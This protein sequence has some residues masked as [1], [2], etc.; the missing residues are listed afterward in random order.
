MSTTTMFL[1]E[2]VLPAGT[3]PVYLPAAPRAIYVRDG[4]AHFDSDDYSQYIDDGNGITTDGQLTIRVG[5]TDTTLWRWE[6]AGG[7][8]GSVDD[9]D[10]AFRSAPGTTSQEK[11]QADLDLDPAF[12]WLIRLDSVHFPPGG[13]AWTHMHQGPGVRICLDGEI[14]IETDGA[15]NVYGPGQ[16]WAEKGVLPV[17]APTTSESS[18][19]FI[20][21]FVLPQHTRGVSSFRTV[22]PE[23]RKKPNTQSYHI[24]SER[25]IGPVG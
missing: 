3:L 14:T 1:Y 23:D 6:L 9:R 25:F 10:R 20:R 18:T 19:T 21:C 15:S 17:L 4:G 16:A 24:F 12:R 22:L 2:D 5:A 7:V 8:N 11:L 13:T